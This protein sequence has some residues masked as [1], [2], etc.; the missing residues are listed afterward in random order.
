MPPSQKPRRSA[1]PAPAKPV[2]RVAIIVTGIVLGAI[3][4]TVMWGITELAG[5]DSGVR[6][7]AYLTI[8]IAMLGAG[9]AAF[10]GAVGATRRGERVTP[11]L[12][13]RRRNR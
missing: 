8:T 4:G 1:A 9:V 11:R 3:W 2:N 5:Q 7:W 13:G 10:F 6:G 12:F